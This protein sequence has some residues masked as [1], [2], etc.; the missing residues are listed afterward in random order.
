VTPEQMVGRVMG[1]VRLFVLA[2][3]APAVLLF[4]W[5]ADHHTPLDAMFVAAFGF[6]TVA[7]AVAMTPA[8]RNEVR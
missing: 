5:V 4:G 6:L 7:V 2:G 8:I 1:A 3:I